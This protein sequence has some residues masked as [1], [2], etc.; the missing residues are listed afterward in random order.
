MRVA[1]AA[2][3][4]AASLCAQDV[5]WIR[6]WESAQRQR[7][8]VIGSVGRIAPANEPGTPLIVHGRV[9][10]RDGVA[11]AQNVVVF[12]YQTDAA[13][14]YNTPGARGW[15]LRGWARS[16]ANGRFELRTIRPASYPG[17]GPP[18]HIHVTIDG[19]E[20]GR[21]WT[22]EIHFADDPLLSQREKRESA[23]KGKF[24]GVRPVTTRDGV[25]HVEF[26][27]RIQERGTF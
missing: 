19:P 20:L 24:G 4:V 14:V 5:D 2:L 7:P 22:E 18:A 3:F 9:F 12:A 15:R 8:R 1:F 13:G 11:P 27:I 10:Q 26:N 6:E 21:R 17:N 23:A 16:D 25:H